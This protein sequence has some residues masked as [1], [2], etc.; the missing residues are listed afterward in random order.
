[1][2]LSRTSRLLQYI[3]F[4]EWRAAELWGRSVPSTRATPAPGP[5]ARPRLVG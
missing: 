4:R 5:V 1:M 3:N 2:S